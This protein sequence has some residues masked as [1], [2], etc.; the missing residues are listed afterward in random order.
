MCRNRWVRWK[1][2]QPAGAVA[3]VEPPGQLGERLVQGSRHIRPV[4][5]A[6]EQQ[7]QEKVAGA[8]SGRG[9]LAQ[10]GSG[11]FLLLPDDRDDLGIDQDGVRRPVDLCLLVA[12]PGH[13]RSRLPGA[14]RAAGQRQQRVCV[15]HEDLADPAAEAGLQHHDPH[16]LR[17]IQA[18]GI[19]FLAELADPCHDLRQ[20]GAVYDIQAR[21]PPAGAGKLPDPVEAGVPGS[22]FPPSRLAGGRRGRV[23]VVVHEQVELL[24]M[25]QHRLGVRRRYPLPGGG[26]AAGLAG[27]HVPE[28]VLHQLAHPGRVRRPAA[29]R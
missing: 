17:V 23:L 19:G 4:G 8:R 26:A 5:V 15:Q 12:E 20:G 18:A 27:P 1:S 21:V 6:V 13:H 25:D 9:V 22:Q 14:C 7:A 11:P 16:R 29:A 3:D 28:E 10:P 24:G 2:T